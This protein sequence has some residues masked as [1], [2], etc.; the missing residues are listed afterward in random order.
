MEILL[1]KKTV[2]ADLEI[3]MEVAYK[4]Q[5]G[6]FTKTGKIVNW[7]VLDG[8]MNFSLDNSLGLYRAVELK[9]IKKQP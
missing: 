9:L 5:N 6:D 3:G 2:D 1:F 8:I 7:I 4:Y